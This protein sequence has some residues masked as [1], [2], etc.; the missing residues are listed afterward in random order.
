MLYPRAGGFLSFPKVFCIPEKLYWHS[1]VGAV[2][3]AAR[4]TLLCYWIDAPLQRTVTLR[5]ANADYNAAKFSKCRKIETKESRAAIRG[6]LHL[7]YSNVLMNSNL[8]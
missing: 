7:L 5:R 2:S 3:Q 6:H 8:Y 4:A 1:S